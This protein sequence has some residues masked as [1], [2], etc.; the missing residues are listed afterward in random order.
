MGERVSPLPQPDRPVLNLPTV[1]G[2]KAELTRVVGYIVY[3]YDLAVCRQSPIQAV[4]ELGV[5]QLLALTT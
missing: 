1:D 2:C 5:E 4:T 3:R